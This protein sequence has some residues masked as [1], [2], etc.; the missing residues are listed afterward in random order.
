METVRTY[1]YQ[2]RRRFSELSEDLSIRISREIS[3]DGFFV[4][5]S[6]NTEPF[7]NVEIIRK[8]GVERIDLTSTPEETPNEER[9]RELMKK[10]GFTDED[11]DMLLSEKASEG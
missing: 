4:T 9:I 8:D 1:L 7:S 6:R 3:K 5:I 2:Q 11:I 10:D